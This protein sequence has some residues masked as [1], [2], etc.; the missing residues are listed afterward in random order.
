MSYAHDLARAY[1]EAL[2]A[3]DHRRADQ[4]EWHV[5]HA[6][7]V[8]LRDRPE[9]SVANRRGQEQRAE[10][11]RQRWKREQDCEHR[12]FAPPEAGLFA[13]ERDFA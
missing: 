8:V 7:A 5:N 3:R 2:Y 10:A 6:G 11:E 13:D 1:N 12:P 9:W 4:V